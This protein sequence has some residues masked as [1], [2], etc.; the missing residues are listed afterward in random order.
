MNTMIVNAGKFEHDGSKNYK[1]CSE[2]LITW[3]DVINLI[4]NDGLDQYPFCEVDFHTDGFTHTISFHEFQ[5]PRD[6][7]GPR[8]A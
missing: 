2:P 6:Y 7:K 1:V 5:Q 8:H 3:A 4:K